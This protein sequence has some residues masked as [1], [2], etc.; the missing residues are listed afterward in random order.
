[1]PGASPPEVKTAIR[2]IVLFKIQK[3]KNSMKNSKRINP[4]IQ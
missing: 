2:L 3:F 4:K 1:M